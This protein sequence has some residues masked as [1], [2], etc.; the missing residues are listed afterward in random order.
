MVEMMQ[1][2]CIPCLSCLGAVLGAKTED[3]LLEHACDDKGTVPLRLELSLFVRVSDED[4]IARV[5]VLAKYLLISPTLCFGMVS[6]EIICCFHSVIFCCLELHIPL[7]GC[8][9]RY[10]GSEGA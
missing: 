9:R 3:P 10:Q 8:V 4:H 7:G 1:V 2:V 6:V 5:N